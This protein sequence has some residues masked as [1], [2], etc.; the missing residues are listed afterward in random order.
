MVG[1]VPA[2]DPLVK[3]CDVELYVA[4]QSVVAPDGCV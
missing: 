1:A 3:V 4:L 2:H